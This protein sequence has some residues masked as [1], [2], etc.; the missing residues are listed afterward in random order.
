MYVRRMVKPTILCNNAE[1]NI[2][3]YS[4]SKGG[5]SSYDLCSSSK[6]WK[7]DNIRVNVISPG[8]NEVSEW[9]IYSTQ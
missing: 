4:V 2:K 5:Y 6:P 1:P 3:S 8:R 7:K 9:I